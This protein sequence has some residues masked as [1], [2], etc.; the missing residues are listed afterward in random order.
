MKN[1]L[2]L[3]ALSAS[4]I[5]REHIQTLFVLLTLAMLV[6]GLGAPEDMNIT[7]R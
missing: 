3:L 2:N 5:K 6:L 4:K 7:G 1:K